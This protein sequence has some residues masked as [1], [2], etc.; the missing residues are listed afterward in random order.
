MEPRPRPPNVVVNL[1]ISLVTTS[2][3]II[4]QA[5]WQAHDALLEARLFGLADVAMGRGLGGTTGWATPQELGLALEELAAALGDVAMRTFPVYVAPLSLWA[6]AQSLWELL[7]KDLGTLLL[8]RTHDSAYARFAWLRPI[9]LTPFEAPL[10]APPGADLTPNCVFNLFWETL[11]C[12]YAA[13][14]FAQASLVTHDDLLG[15]FDQS[16]SLRARTL[17]GPAHIDEVLHVRSLVS[18]IG[19]LDAVTLRRAYENAPMRHLLSDPCYWILRRC[20]KYLGEQ[21]H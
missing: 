6:C 15:I 10:L 13:F 3:D 11:W 4:F 12:S 8:A 2:L 14:S 20:L 1:T 16:F 17:H 7:C 21:V 9:G 5:C 19:P 18:T